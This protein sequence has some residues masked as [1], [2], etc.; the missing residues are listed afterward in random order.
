MRTKL[1]KILLLILAGLV[2][3]GAYFGYRNRA[4]DALYVNAAGYPPSTGGA[5][6][7]VAAIKR[8]AT[9]RGGRATELLLSLAM[10]E[11]PAQLLW[12]DTRAEAIKQLSARADPS[13]ALT[14]AKMLQ[15]HERFGTRKAAAEALKSMPCNHECIR[16]VL[17]YLERISAG[18]LNH[19]DRFL[20][21][22]ENH[23]VTDRLKKEEEALYA[24]LYLV[25]RNNKSDALANLISTYGL[26]SP[27]PSAFGLAVATRMS[28]QE[29]CPYLLQ[30]SRELQKFP[31]QVYASPRQELQNAISS[32][33]CR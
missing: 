5:S 12:P 29:S 9:Y 10:G 30:S 33:N 16:L 4:M 19:E 24:D 23:D 15:P 2:C 14:L 7:S 31:P 26:G 21:L 25:L 8:L 32:L 28:L 11:G 20:Q 27:D 1:V 6:E 3:V 18:E 13:I 22:P 17:H